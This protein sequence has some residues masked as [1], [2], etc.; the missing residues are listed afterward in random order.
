MIMEISN[1]APYQKSGPA[2]RQTSN[3]ANLFGSILRCISN[4]KDTRTTR[5]SAGEALQRG[6]AR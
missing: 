2:A 3:C 1:G 6:S 4:S 5:V